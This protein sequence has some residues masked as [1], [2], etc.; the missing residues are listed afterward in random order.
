MQTK[1]IIKLLQARAAKLMANVDSDENEYSR[2]QKFIDKFCDEIIETLKDSM[3]IVME[4]IIPT[5]PED[6]ESTN[7]ELLAEMQRFVVESSIQKLVFY[8]SNVFLYCYYC[9]E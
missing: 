8:L 4:D 6:G 3:K 7:Q 1:I 5:Y 2:E 9:L